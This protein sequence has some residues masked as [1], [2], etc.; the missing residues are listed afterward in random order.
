MAN[1]SD[2]SLPA[3]WFTRFTQTFP[4]AA[5]MFPEDT[6][7]MP[8]L[9]IDGARNALTPSPD[10]DHLRT[11][12]LDLRR[13]G[14]PSQEYPAAVETL[15]AA[16]KDTGELTEEEE[17]QLKTA[18]EEMAEAANHAD[19]AGVPAAHAA[20]VTSAE[21]RGAVT[22]LR[23]ESGTA[24]DYAPGQT[25]PVMQVGRQGVWHR[26]A[27]ALPPS[28][29]GQLE[30]H[31]TD[32]LEV[33]VGDWVTIGGAGGGEA[34]I[35][36]SAL[37]VAEGT[38]LAAAKALVFDLLEREE[39][40]QVDLVVGA[41]NVDDVYDATTFATLAKAQPWLNVTWVVREGGAAQ[42]AEAGLPDVRHLHLPLAQAVAGAGVWWGRDV[43]ISSQRAEEIA[44]AMRANG[45]PEPQILG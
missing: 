10:L 16:L 41:E 26:L 42:W 23:L 28:T 21:R 44:E 30:F 34:S 12:A 1:L 31:V 18:G 5:G 45:A 38:G 4:Q 33:S 8:Q 19:A 25:L 24:V 29:V 2:P 35:S 3:A 36:K 11:L 6:K 40:P 43:L 7:E 22:V 14:F 27:P 17:D 9:L 37:L 39:R 32:E 20:Q 15:I 13:T